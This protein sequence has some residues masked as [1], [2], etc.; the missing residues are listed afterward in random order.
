MNVDVI[1]P[2]YNQ[3]KYLPQA[4]EST[5]KQGILKKNIYL[6]D[7]CSSDR[8]DLIAS[9]YDINLLK[10]D[11]NSGPAVARNLGIKSSHSEFVAF[12]DADDVMLPGRILSSLTS[13][14][15]SGAGMVCGNYCFWVNRSTITAPFYKR[16]IQISYENMIKNNYVASGSVMIK[17]SV[18]DDVGLF[19]P[20]YLVAE[21]Y[22]LWLRVV[23]KYKI[24][25]IHNPLYLYHRDTINKNSLT[26]NPNNLSLL[27]NN[28]EKIKQESINRRR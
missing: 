21:D 2:I 8:P 1:V 13:L 11:V 14:L 23:E 17:R 4:L 3:A 6:I 7:D 20:E 10:T 19:N 26:S 22:D 25:Y 15:Q 18:L 16:D 27:L 28:V 5:L 24:N 12:L 9:K